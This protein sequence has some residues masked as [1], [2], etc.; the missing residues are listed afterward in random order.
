MGWQGHRHRRGTSPA[1]AWGEDEAGALLL[2]SGQQGHVV[3]CIT[4]HRLR[5]EDEAW[6]ASSLSSG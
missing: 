3:E 2:L 4:S 1:V 5:C 6:A